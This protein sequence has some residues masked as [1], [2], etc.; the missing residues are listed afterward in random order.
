[1]SLKT[2]LRATLEERLPTLF[3]LALDAKARLFP[4]RG[5]PELRLVPILCHRD[6]LAVDIGA[7]HGTYSRP[8]AHHAGQLVAVEPN[9]HLADVLRRR[10]APAIRAGKARI[11]ELALSD[12]DGSIQL[13][14][15]T[16][17]S[18]LASV[19]HRPAADDA[20]EYVTVQRRRL[21]DLDLSRTGFIKIDVEGHEA[22]VVAGARVLLERDRPNLLIEVE[23]RHHPGSLD[24]IRSILEPLDYRGFF[25]LDGAMRPIAAFDQQSHQDRSALNAAGTH[26]LPG[27]TYV[28]NFVFSAREDVVRRLESW[29]G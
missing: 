2:R 12:D 4:D 22:S 14:V 25:L 9:P 29:P 23:D 24:R 15:P 17:Q 27:R 26:R 8:M 28:N 20:G 16:G 3:A 18:G 5:E 1:M 21:D 19:E 13:F 10:L 6:E 11:L 7:N